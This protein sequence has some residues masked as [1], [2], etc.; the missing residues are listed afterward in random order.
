MA[1]I[2]D[3]PITDCF[4]GWTKRTDEQGQCQ[5]TAHED[6]TAS[7]SVGLG[8]NGGIVLKCQAGCENVDILRSI[9]KT[10]SDLYIQRNDSSKP[11][12]KFRRTRP[13]VAANTLDTD[14][15]NVA[16]KDG[17]EQR[18]K[19]VKVYR[20]CDALGK[21]VFEVVR[22]HPKDFK[23]RHYNKSK[24]TIWKGVSE[25]KRPL[26]R[27]PELLAA[28]KD[29]IVYL[30]EGEKDCDRLRE[31]CQLV[32][33]TNCGGAAGGKDKSDQPRKKWL[34]QYTESLRGRIVIIIPDS[35]EPGR[36]HAQFVA[37]QLYGTA[38][39]V[40]ILDLPAPPSI[41]PFNPVKWDVSDWLDQGGTREQFMAAVD[42]ARSRPWMPGSPANPGDYSPDNPTSADGPLPICNFDDPGFIPVP[43]DEICRRIREHCND[44]PRR[45][46]TTLFVHQGASIH[47]LE[48]N[49]QLWSFVGS[50]AGSPPVFHRE[51]GGHTKEEV[52]HRLSQSSTQYAAVETL[53][54][55]PQIPSHYY[56]LPTL[57]QPSESLETL[58]QFLDFFRPASLEDRSLLLSLF[59]TLFWGG[60]GGKRPI[61]L[62]TS[63]EGRGAGKSTIADI[64]GRLAG[65]VISLHAAEDAQR[66]KSRLL[67]SEGL[68]RRI[69]VLDNVK[70]MRFSWAELES[71]VTAETISGHRLHVGE[72]SRPN[73][74]TWIVTLNGASLSTDI[75][76]RVIT[77]KI[78]RPNYTG[79]W[80]DDVCKFLES[81]RLQV[82]AD[83]LAYLSGDRNANSAHSRWG[84]WERDILGLCHD[85]DTLRELIRSRQ[86]ESDVEAE[87]S[88]EIEEY[89]RRKLE[90]LRYDTDRSKIF[91]PSSVSW[92][93]IRDVTGDK[94]MSKTTASR[95][96]KQRCNEG[97]VV[98]LAY[99]ARNDF[100]RGFTWVGNF[101]SGEEIYTDLETRIST[102]SGN[103]F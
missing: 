20:Y 60:P 101:F 43:V 100:G 72:G 45:V 36:R 75:A 16:P 59:A 15:D 51:A 61:F 44:W 94:H 13:D 77:I 98:H 96:L 7:L 103:Y 42:A 95:W 53:P 14:R 66:M 30:V 37:S 22:F 90:E 35:D 26:Y 71:L 33:T 58:Y 54:H 40:S 91:I 41:D 11:D 24:K 34:P 48:K 39:E 38:S 25:E 49:P 97:A 32:S 92:E 19:I 21:L 64:C 57:P 8:K 47:W 63:D 3:Y 83:L 99:S 88:S 6:G 81:S 85:P 80:Y 79:N 23:Q 78:A 70:T 55:S 65:G 102:S 67:S 68:S 9:R 82:I 28:P 31:T 87:E 46:G 74:L 69:A 17:G 52:F 62:V 27:L 2:F 86:Q 50:R 18:S 10:W 12:S 56:A 89:F 4:E 1:S 84:A 93:W 5:C 76:Q 73:T 29:A